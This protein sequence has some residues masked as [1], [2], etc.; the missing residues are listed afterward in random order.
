MRRFAFRENHIPEC[1]AGS[2]PGLHSALPRPEAIAATAEFPDYPPRQ[3]TWRRVRYRT[4]KASGPERIELEWWRSGDRRSGLNVSALKLL[5]EA[6]AFRSIGLDRRQ[7]LWKV[8]RFAET[9]T[10]AA[11]LADLP[12][13]AASHSEHLA[14]EGNVTLPDLTIGEHVLQDYA[15]IRMSLKA[16]PVGLLRRSFAR[17][18]YVP[19]QQLAAIDNGRRVKVAGIVLVRQRPDSAKGVVFATLE[20][21]TGAA[22]IIIW[23]QSFEKYRRIALGARLLGVIGKLQKESGVIHV[24]VATLTDLSAHL[25]ELGEEQPPG[26]HFLSNAD[27]V[28]RPVNEDARVTRRGPIAHGA[29]MVL[30]KSRNFQ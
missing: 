24:V 21:E 3:F 4:V 15:T 23:P 14:S 26:S 2:M 20:D 29:M 13:F 27:G 12:L 25:D 5:A 10:P 22:N 17:L 7:A 9:G 16:H 6:D 18:G 19:A 28:R 30:P 8:T 11:L 1:A